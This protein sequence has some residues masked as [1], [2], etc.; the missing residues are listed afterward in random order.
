MWA[1]EAAL[2]AAARRVDTWEASIVDRAQRAKSL[3]NRLSALTGTAQSPDRMIEVTVDAAGRLVDL[4]L[5]ERTRQHPA[6][7]TARQIVATT[8]AAQADLRRQ[9]TEATRHT[10]G[11]DPAGQAIIDSHRPRREGSGAAR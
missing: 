9:V 6:A 3:A 1:D 2:D 11:D 10:L 8:E 7:Q 5:D 4:R